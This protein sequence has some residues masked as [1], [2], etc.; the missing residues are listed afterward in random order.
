MGLDLGIDV[1]NVIYPWLSVYTRYVECRKGLQPGTL[2]DI[3]LSWTW[4]KDQWGME[5]PEFLE[6]YTAGVH[7]GVIF[8]EGDP[9]P[10]SLAAMRRLQLAGHRLHY[11]TDRVIEGV[12]EEHAF[13]AT[14]AWL[15]R[16]GFPVDSITITA[17]KSSVKTDVFLDDAPHN[18]HALY[19]AGHP[20]PVVWSLPHNEMLPWGYWR[21]HSWRDF[22]LLANRA[23]MPIPAA[24][25]TLASDRKDTNS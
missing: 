10:G 20:L 18:I 2:D 1:D 7:A 25:A 9:L 14:H 16:H 3:A 24:P 11:V 13:T 8:H 21:A 5:T 6:H 15:H 12:T 23:P 22:E 19:D 4:Y 17:D